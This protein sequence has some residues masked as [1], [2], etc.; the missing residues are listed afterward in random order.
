M[1]LLHWT[2]L[3]PGSEENWYGDSHDQKDSGIVN[4]NKMV[5]HINEIGHPIF[6]STSALSCGILR[7]RR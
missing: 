2:F 4:A 3:G 7:Q 5:L 1:K 6:I